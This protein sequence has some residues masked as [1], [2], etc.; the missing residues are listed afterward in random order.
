MSMKRK[1]AVEFLTQ[2]PY[3]FA[4]LVGFKKLGRLHNKWI[5]DMLCGKEDKTLQAHRG[6]Y[7]TTC[8]AVALALIIVL[9]PNLRVMFMRK[10]DTDTKEIIAQVKKIL[11]NPV[12]RYFVRVIYGVDLKFVKSNENE[13]TTNLTNDPRGSSQLIGMGIG[14]SLTGKHFDLIFT[15]DIVNVSDRIS[16]AER[17]RTKLIYQELRNIVNR[18]GRIYNTGTPWHKEDAFSLMPNPE[19]YD[20]Y[21]TG[22]IETAELENIKSM[23]IASLFAA[24]YE[25]RHIAAEDVIFENPRIGADPALAEQGECHI[26]ASYG[27]E[28]FTAFTICKKV[29]GVYYIFGKLWSKHID[30]CE[31]EI[32]SIRKRFNA[33]RI[34]CEKNADKGY[35]A[36]ELRKKG[37]RVTA[38]H[39]D[40]NKFLKITS[41]LK[42]EW[43]NVHF[44]MGTDED[45]IRQITDYTET[46]EHD[47]APDSAASIVRHL[48]NRNNEE[49]ADE[50]NPYLQ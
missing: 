34:L 2:K 11:E 17:E 8:V 6:S 7:K 3:K 15:D 33:G 44:V 42:A 30:D 1:E 31:D 23:M 13:I 47:D 20:C 10:T 29:Q 41:Y 39:E 4:H 43:R 28:D 9:L 24:N 25:L 37:E 46:A 48:W 38:Y 49:N 45:Y 35:L 22:L 40:T 12:M 21:T 27:G 19:K 5:V 50:W 36:K 16:K 18:G 26:D 14:G 32:I